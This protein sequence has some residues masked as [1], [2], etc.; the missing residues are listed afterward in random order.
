MNPCFHFW[1]KVSNKQAMMRNTVVMKLPSMC[2]CACK[3]TKICMFAISY[4]YIRFGLCS[5]YADIPS[6]SMGVFMQDHSQLCPYDSVLRCQLFSWEIHP[7]TVQK[8]L[9]KKKRTCI[10]SFKMDCSK[11]WENSLSRQNYMYTRHLLFQK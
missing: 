4:K 11:N 3:V 10:Y 2:S 8:N 6:I 5:Q 1:G 9:F 7:N